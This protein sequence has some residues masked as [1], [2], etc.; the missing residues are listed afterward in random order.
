M[1]LLSNQPRITQIDRMQDHLLIYLSDHTFFS[2]TERRLLSLE[3]ARSQVPDDRSTEFSEAIHL[4]RKP[5]PPH[6]LKR[7]WWA[8]EQE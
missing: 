2:V 4:V 7:G 1:N 3:I 5:S 8:A 6:L